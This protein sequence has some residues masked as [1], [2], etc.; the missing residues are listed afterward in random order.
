[1]TYR[2]IK[3]FAFFV[4][5]GLSVT[6]KWLAVKTP[7]EMTLYCVGWAG[8]YVK[9]Y[10][11][12]SNPVSTTLFVQCTSSTKNAASGLERYI[13]IAW[14]FVWRGVDAISRES[15]DSDSRIAVNVIHHDRS[16]SI[17]G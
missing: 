17:C 8:V 12:Q 4:T 7:S 5:V 2:P 3:F 15:W 11:I 14:N 16:L 9:L 6:V 1:M 13:G 10:S